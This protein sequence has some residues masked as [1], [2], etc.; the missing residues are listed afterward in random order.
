VGQVDEAKERAQRQIGR[1]SSVTNFRKQ[2]VEIVSGKWE[3][4]PR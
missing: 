4:I 3:V 1:P 2:V